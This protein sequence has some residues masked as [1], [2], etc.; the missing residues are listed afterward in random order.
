M[1][2]RVYP[3]CI[4]V[5]YSALAFI[6]LLCASTVCSVREFPLGLRTAGLALRFVLT[7]VVFRSQTTYYLYLVV[8]LEMEMFH[9]DVCSKSQTIL[10]ALSFALCSVPIVEDGAEHVQRGE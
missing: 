1:L 3:V 7:V 4:C 6:Q 9:T 8:Q 10:N 2:Y 5:Q